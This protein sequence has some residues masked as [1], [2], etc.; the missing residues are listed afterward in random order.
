MSDAINARITFSQPWEIRNCWMAFRLADGSHD[1]TL[2]DT[3]QDAVK[4]QSDENLCAYFCFRNALGGVSPK[5]CQIF[6]DLHRHLYDAGGR[7]ADPDSPTGGPDL[8]LSQ[9]GY[10][11]MSKRQ[12]MRANWRAN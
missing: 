9:K 8:I 10:E 12:G 5:D 3:K 2:Y 1:G 7:L 6:L 4:H 11:H